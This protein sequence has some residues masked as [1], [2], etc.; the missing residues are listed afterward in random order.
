MDSQPIMAHPSIAD[1]PENALVQ[2]LLSDPYWRLNIL[3]IRGIPQ[4]VLDFQRVPLDD[5]PGDFE[6][7]VDILL[8]AKSRPDSATA[9]EV[10]RVKVG[11]KAL[12]SEQPNKLHEYTRGVRQAN[13]LARV[14]FSQVY[15]YVIV[16]VDSREQNIGHISCAGPSPKLRRKIAQ[17][18]SVSDLDPRI[19][20]LHYEFAQAMDNNPL[21]AGFAS[22]HLVRLAQPVAQPAAL[23]AWVAQTIAGRGHSPA[24]EN[25][26]TGAVS[27]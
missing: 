15:L 2:H 8:C 21:R 27:P 24:T 4:E 3:G 19:G 10:K 13:C 14:G 23:T 5:A 9:I 25:L 26:G 12:R 22:G 7:D 20:L 1:I 17:T 6:G 18:L 16:V 11:A